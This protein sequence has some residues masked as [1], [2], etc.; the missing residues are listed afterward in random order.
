MLQ[1]RRERG[2]KYIQCE[3]IKC[4]YNEYLKRLVVVVL[5]EKAPTIRTR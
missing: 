1:D 4:V 3:V 5:G 2:A